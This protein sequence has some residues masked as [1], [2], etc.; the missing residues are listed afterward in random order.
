VVSRIGGKESIYIY[1]YGKE[2]V[3]KMVAVY[4]RDGSRVLEPAPNHVRSLGLFM[5]LFPLRRLYYSR[6]DPLV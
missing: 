2:M 6:F 4:S 5:S 3:A 1:M